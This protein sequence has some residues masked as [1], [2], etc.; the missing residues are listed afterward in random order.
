MLMFLIVSMQA[1]RRW[2]AALLIALA[3]ATSASAQNV[4]ISTAVSTQDLKTVF[5]VWEV[6]RE[7][8]FLEMQAAQKACDKATFED[9]R[10]NL[11]IET[12]KQLD[13][14]SLRI[15]IITGEAFIPRAEDWPLLTELRW[16]QESMY[17][18]LR[19]FKRMRYVPCEGE[20]DP[21]LKA[22][23]DRACEN[24]G[25]GYFY[26]PGTET[27]TS[28]E[29]GEIVEYTVG[30]HNG[31]IRVERGRGDFEWGEPEDEVQPEDEEQ[32]EEE[33]LEEDEFPIGP[34]LRGPQGVLRSGG[35]SGDGALINTPSGQSFDIPSLAIE[36]FAL[37]GGTVRRGAFATETA[38]LPQTLIVPGYNFDTSYSGYGVTGKLSTELSFGGFSKMLLSGTLGVDYTSARSTDT[39]VQFLQGFG[40]PGIDPTPGAYINSPTD[41]LTFDYWSQKR[42]SVFSLDAGIPLTG[43]M[44]SGPGDM[45]I[46]YSID[47][48]AGFRTGMFTQTE[49]MLATLDTPAFGGNSASTVEYNT[50]FDGMY[51]GALGGIGLR[52][53]TPLGDSGLFLQK[54]ASL[55]AGINVYNLAVDDALDADGLG[56]GLNLHRTSSFDASATVPYLGFDTKI[57]IGNDKFAASILGGIAYGETANIDYQRLDDGQ[58]PTVDVLP[59]LSYKGGFTVQVRF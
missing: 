56:G 13:L 6:E 9:R 46:E 44:N 49:R 36:T 47:A 43:G 12:Q 21:A 51:Y 45:P 33:Q 35:L 32:Q 41:M 2:P 58:N 54:E 16:E 53:E 20:E 34:V 42:Q 50:T 10:E 17:S 59:A 37:N 18:R 48:F 23:F 8:V 7:A 22:A 4:N 1:M 25:R 57:G 30:V 39:D 24:I 31:E 52:A 38:T 55:R 40:I 15:E 19:A 29:Q 28:Y 5:N 26:I 14:L 3:L 27:C 11:V